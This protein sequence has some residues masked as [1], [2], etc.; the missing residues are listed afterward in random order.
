MLRTIRRPQGVRSVYVAGEGFPV[1]FLHGFP[2]DHTMWS[3]QLDVVARRARVV[4]PDLAG[5]GQS[6]LGSGFPDAAQPLTM[7]FLADD[8]AVILKELAITEPV[9]LCGLSMGG[10]VSFPFISANPEQVRA[11]V[12][13]DTRSQADLE[14]GIQSRLSMANRVM[15][16]GPAIAAQAMLS[17]IFAPGTDRQLIEEARQVMLRTRPET[18]AAAQRGMAVRPDS[19]PM[20]A[21][22]SCPTLLIVGEQDVVS[23]PE[24]M[25]QMA[26]AIGPNAKLEVI[27]NAGH[28]TPMEQPEEFNRVLLKFLDSLN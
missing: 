23:P 24:E 22:I 3:R 27:R 8:L 9:V 17:R 15:H 4:A 2:L 16:E 21:S 12:L 14:A 18:I 13:C 26:A 19:T 5:F 6:D 1:V 25:Q 10:Y 7:S 28:M 20:L 11:L